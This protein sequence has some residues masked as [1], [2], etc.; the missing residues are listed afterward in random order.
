[1]TLGKVAIGLDDIDSP[2]GQCTTHFA[3]LLVEELNPI[4]DSW[5]D[6]PNLIR[7]NPNIPY[8]TRGNG[9]IAL[10]F[11]ISNDKIDQLLPLIQDMITSYA[12]S[13]YPN[14]N[15]GVVLLRGNTPSSV[16]DFASQTVW[17]TVPRSLALR[18]LEQNN[19][20]YFERG[21]GRGLIGALAAVG[22][23]LEDDYTYECIAYR[24]QDQCGEPRDVDK[25]SVIKMNE[26]TMGR[27]FANVDSLSGNI[28]IEPQGPDPVIYGIRG[29]TPE[30]VIEA[31][32][33]VRSK[34]TPERWMVFRTN[35]GTAEH[36]KH[37]TRVTSLRPYMSTRVIATVAEK[38]RIMEGGHVFFRVGDETGFVDC[39]AYEPTGDFRWIVDKLIVGDE[40]ILLAGVRPA[41]RTHG[42]TLNL[43]GIHIVTVADQVHTSNPLCRQC[44]KRMKSAG[45]NKGFKCNHCGFKDS[46]IKKVETPI[47]RSVEAGIYLPQESAQRHLTRPHSRLLKK[48]LIS[49]KKLIDKWHSH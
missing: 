29:E 18:I 19:L 2:R 16:S 26:I 4:I 5:K 15:P 21:N 11:T 17:K 31:F 33:L 34:Q 43:E 32:N 25:A 48:N 42:L 9:S 46:S 41:S 30:D 1:M 45:K 3:S 27:T 35:Q 14:T 49:P 7:L 44:G 24:K 22:H 20:E 39:A 10:R 36:L 38:P 12:E 23:G 8:R 6:Y 47:T 40:L 13:S 28:L 37:T